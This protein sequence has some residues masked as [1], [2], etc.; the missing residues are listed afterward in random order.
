MDKTC[1]V[2]SWTIWYGMKL[3]IILKQEMLLLEN[4]PSATV[5]KEK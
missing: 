1:K 3:L 4:E 2:N 5:L